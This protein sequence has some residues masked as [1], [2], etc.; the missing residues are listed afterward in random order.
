MATFVTNTLLV[1]SMDILTK[2]ISPIF[3][4]RQ[5]QIEKIKLKAEEIQAKQLGRLLERVAAP[6]GENN[7][8]LKI[9]ITIK[10]SSNRFLFRP[11][12]T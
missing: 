7:I 1:E 9:S 8:S 11:T 3:S 6:S 2:A 10:I 4:L 5:K 12:T